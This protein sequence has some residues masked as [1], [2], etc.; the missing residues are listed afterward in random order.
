MHLHIHQHIY[1]YTCIHKTNH[2]QP[3]KHPPHFTNTHTAGSAL[4]VPR[5][6]ASKPRQA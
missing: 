1:M 5:R 6:R 4:Q 3:P 2:P